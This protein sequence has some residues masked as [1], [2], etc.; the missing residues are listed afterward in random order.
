MQTFLLTGIIV[1]GISTLLKVIRKRLIKQCKSDIATHGEETAA[2]ILDVEMLNAARS[3]PIA[4]IRLRLQVEPKRMRN[5]V[6]ELDRWTKVSE[7][8]ALRIG[9]RIHVKYDPSKPKR[10][11]M[12]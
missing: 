2:T 6:I 7:L 11:I 4:K 12:L 9:A 5:Y 3:G 8:A 10:V 1:F